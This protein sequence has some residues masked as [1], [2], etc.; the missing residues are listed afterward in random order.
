[1]LSDMIAAP[2]ALSRAASGGGVVSA[3]ISGRARMEIP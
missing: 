3:T 2:R 1:M